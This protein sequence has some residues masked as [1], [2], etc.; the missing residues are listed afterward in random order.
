[1]I[2]LLSLVHYQEDNGWIRSQEL[3]L[4]KEK[5]ASRIGTYSA[6]HLGVTLILE[7]DAL[8]G[9]IFP[10]CMQNLLS[11]MARAVYGRLLV[12][13]WAITPRLFI[14]RYPCMSF[15]RKGAKFL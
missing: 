3:M 10:W 1:M 6:T 7:A 8:D 14:V 11:Q 13:R 2:F 5:T 12:A 4:C 15:D 9:L